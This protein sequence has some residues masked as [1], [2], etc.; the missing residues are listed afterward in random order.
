M[1][2]D[3]T[4]PTELDAKRDGKEEVG[5]GERRSEPAQGWSWRK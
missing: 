5:K 1:K 4:L 3:K 2:W